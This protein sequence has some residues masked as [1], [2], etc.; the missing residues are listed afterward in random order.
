MGTSSRS[1]FPPPSPFRQE[2]AAA[3]VSQHARLYGPGPS[4]TRRLVPPAPACLPVL[5]ALCAVTSRVG[6]PAY[7]LHDCHY[8]FRTALRG[9]N[10]S[11]SVS[12]LYL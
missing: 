2:P 11:T 8:F 6:M 9:L 12:P 5:Y 1:R 10:I 7:Y 3:R 4:A